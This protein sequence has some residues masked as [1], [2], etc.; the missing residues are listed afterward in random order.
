LKRREN[1]RNFS[2]IAHLDHGNSTLA[3]RI[4]EN[5][6]SVGMQNSGLAVSLAALHLNPIAAVPGAVFSF[7]HNITGPI[8]AKH[9]SK[10]L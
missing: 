6:K 2:I 8:L 7:I 1:I 10:K 3:D 4:L 9:W 5:T